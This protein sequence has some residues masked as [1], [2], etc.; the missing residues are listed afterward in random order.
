M[1]MLGLSS[2]NGVVFLFLFRGVSFQHMASTL[3]LVAFEMIPKTDFLFCSW[4]LMD[5]KYHHNFATRWKPEYI[6]WGER[7]LTPLAPAVFSILGRAP[8]SD[9][10]KPFCAGCAWW[11]QRGRT[12]TH[13]RCATA[14]G[15][16][17]AAAQVQHSSDGKGRHRAQCRRAGCGHN[18]QRQRCARRADGAPRCPS[19]RM[20]GA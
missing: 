17:W 15:R 13:A 8:P 12:R 5:P 7:T 3:N 6:E 2:R 4:N 19:S 9:R 11:R 14:E 16:L 1:C 10:P 20:V 18:V